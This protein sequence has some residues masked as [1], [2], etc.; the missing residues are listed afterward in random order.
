[1]TKKRLT[2]AI[3]SCVLAVAGLALTQGSAEAATPKCGYTAHACVA[4]YNT[5]DYTHSVRV[6]GQCLVFH[7]AGNSYQFVYSHVA[8]SKGGEPSV[9]TY[10]GYHCEGNTSG[11]DLDWQWDG[12]ADSN[13]Y[14]WLR[15]V[16][17]N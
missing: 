8:V 9:Q 12:N 10:G 17:D 11:V 14:R 1:M 2:S 15:V 5:S 6:N 13:N 3:A 7:N 16:N 4:I